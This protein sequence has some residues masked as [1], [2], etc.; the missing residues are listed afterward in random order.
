[1]QADGGGLAVERVA[2]KPLGDGGVE[3]RVALAGFPDDLRL[4]R[5]PL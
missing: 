1:M 4:W 5:P 2:H 3:E